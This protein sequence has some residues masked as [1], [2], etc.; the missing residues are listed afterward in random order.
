MYFHLVAVFSS[1]PENDTKESVN[2]VSKMETFQNTLTPG[3]LLSYSNRLSTARKSFNSLDRSSSWTNLPNF[4][5]SGGKKTRSPKGNRK[6]SVGKMGYMN[7][8]PEFVLVHHLANPDFVLLSAQAETQMP[9][10]NERILSLL[11]CNK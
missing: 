3:T 10:I 4:S 1:Q 2:L 9:G 5:A 8:I 6:Y 11:Q 7:N